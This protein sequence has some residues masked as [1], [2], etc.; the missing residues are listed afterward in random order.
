MI[1]ALN[2]AVKHIFA[3]PQIHVFYLSLAHSNRKRRKA[4]AEGSGLLPANI[5]LAMSSST[6]FPQPY[7]PLP[8]LFWPR[9]A[10]RPSS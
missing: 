3:P 10:I 2:D 1:F 6:L 4:F 7:R 8:R 9:T 5:E